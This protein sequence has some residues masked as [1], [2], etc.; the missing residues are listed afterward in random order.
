MN[1]IK[2]HKVLASIIA[3]IAIIIIASAA[4][5]KNNKTDNSQVNNQSTNASNNSKKA[6]T[7]AKIGDTV[8]DG[9]FEFTVKSLDCG[10]AEIVSPDSD[11]L[12][13]TA[14]GQYCVAA[15]TVKNI[16]SQQQGFFSS[17]Q[18]LLD[19]SSK[20][21]SSDDV[22]TSYATPS[23][24]Q[25]NWSQINPGN[26]ID[27]TVVFDIPKEVAPTFAELHD[28]AYSGGVKVSLK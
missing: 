19:S 24:Q 5:G 3:V 14:Q 17:N 9:K 23:S 22:A 8:R 16:G 13:K 12:R 21:Y 15:L 25:S 2:A 1:W 10:K 4:G 7:E 20:Q 26:S 6:P 28:S 27:A 11:I 18:K